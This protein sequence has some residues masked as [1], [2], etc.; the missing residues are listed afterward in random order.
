ML[1]RSVT[2]LRTFSDPPE[3][4]GYYLRVPLGIKDDAKD[5]SALFADKLQGGNGSLRYL[6]S[7]SQCFNDDMAF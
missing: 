7:G 1:V 5:C 6:V 2:D 3:L 4:P